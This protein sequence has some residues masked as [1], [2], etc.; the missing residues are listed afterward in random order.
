MIRPSLWTRLTSFF[1]PY[2]I[3]GIFAIISSSVLIRA[4]LTNMRPFQSDESVYLYAAYAIT[5]GVTPYREIFLAHPPLM[6]LIFAA[7]IQVAGTSLV[8]IRVLNYMVFGVSVFLTYLM[9]KVVI[10]NERGAQI[11]LLSAALYA[12][13]PMVI[14]LSITAST[15][16]ILTVFTLSSVIV[17]AKYLD[18]PSRKPLFL[19][20]LFLGLALMT[21]FT[22]IIF[23]AILLLYHIARSFL[24]KRYRRGLVDIVII[25]SGIAIPVGAT[26]FLTLYWHAL[27]QFFMQTYYLQTIRSPLTPSERMN[28]LMVFAGTFSFF[29]ITGI[30]G[31]VYFISKIRQQKNS[32]ILLSMWVYGLNSLILIIFPISLLHYFLFLIP[33]LVFLSAL[34]IEKIGAV[35]SKKSILHT[36]ARAKE[37]KIIALFVLI[38]AGLLLFQN[39]TNMSPYINYLLKNPYTE[40]EVRVGAYIAKV[41]SINDTIWT[42]EPGIAF[43]A[44]R[45]IIAPNSSNWPLQGFF[46]DVFNTT[47][48]DHKGLGIVSPDQFVQAWEKEKV[49]VIIII[50]GAGWVPYPDEI[51]W[52]G[53]QGQKGV[54]DYVKSNYVMR[55]NMKF[56]EVPYTYEIWLRY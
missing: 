14:A 4:V 34:G 10:S 56:T 19:V 5:R 39:A 46:N 55:T 37:R 42:S 47:Y 33:Y 26:V 11:G 52:T 50:R 2:E 44:Q 25:S 17:Y 18:S 7:F 30:T 28:I 6:Y 8:L 38:L 54:A 12:F 41:T 29:L 43:L 40:A 31:A 20:G 48:N 23:A 36:G 51:L 27:P 9:C 24:T 16:T 35:L 22:A 53:F 45:L 3:R 49:K 21:K 32:L 1:L 13:Y 15:E